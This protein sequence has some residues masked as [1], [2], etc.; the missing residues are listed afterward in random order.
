MLSFYDHP[1]KNDYFTVVYRSELIKY[2][3]KVGIP[4]SEIDDFMTVKNSIVLTLGDNLTPEIIV[5]IKENS[6]FL[7]VFDIND[8]SILT[9]TYSYSDEA[10]LIDLIF[11]VGGIQKTKESYNVCIDNDL[12]YTREK[13]VFHSGDWGK[14]FDVVSAGKIRSLPYPPWEL[15]VV[16]NVPWVERKK[17]ALIRGGH[18]YLRVHLF[19]QLLSIG[20]L[21]GNSIFSSNKYTSQFCDDCKMIFKNNKKITFN[22]LNKHPDMSC[23]LKNWATGFNDCGKWNNGC[24][25]RYL[26]LAK[27]FHDKYGG[28]KLSAVEDAFCGSFADANWRD[29]IL[30]RYVFYGDFKLIFSIYAPPRFWEAAEAHTINLVPERMNDQEF[31]PPMQ[32]GVHYITYKEDFSDL[33]DVCNINKEKFQY[34]THNCFELYD[35]WINKQDIHRVSPNLLAYIL[36]EIEAAHGS[37]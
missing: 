36:S 22:Y 13:A 32:D 28:F 11:K 12:N 7:V 1:I 14:Y 4:I 15:A 2:C 27:L 6:N 29:S 8:H 35:T 18:H 20:M 16:Q 21:D 25:P 37:L 31:F 10:M 19:L 33:R 34:I 17:L 3:R 30:N 5:R 26:D 24:I 23:R 9:E